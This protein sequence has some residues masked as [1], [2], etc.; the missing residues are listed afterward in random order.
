MSVFQAH[1]SE[2]TYYKQMLESKT[3]VFQKIN[4]SG[5]KYLATKPVQDEMIELSKKFQV[6]KLKNCTLHN[7]W[8]GKGN[9]TA[10]FDM[11][12]TNEPLLNQIITKI[13]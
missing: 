2:T 7:L 3:K 1:F 11:T 13:R 10:W 5:S 4:K 9:I 6:T 12:L 8:Y